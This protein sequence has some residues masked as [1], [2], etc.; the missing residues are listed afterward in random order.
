MVCGHIHGGHGRFHLGATTIVNASLVDSDYRPIN[1][2]VE[3]ELT[4]RRAPA[5]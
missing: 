2:V 4:G 1:P 5:G 3:I